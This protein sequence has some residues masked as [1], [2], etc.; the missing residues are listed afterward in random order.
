MLKNAG[1]Y[2]ATITIHN[3]V[4]YMKPFSFILFLMLMMHLPMYALDSLILNQKFD[5]LEIAPDTQRVRLLG[6]IAWLLRVR[7]NEK[8]KTMAEEGM[9]LS[10]ELG[11]SLSYYNLN[12]KLGVVFAIQSSYAESISNIR[13]S[14]AY[15]DRNNHK[16][17]EIKY[18]ALLGAVLDYYGDYPQADSLLQNVAQYY[19]ITKNQEKLL[20]VYLS[21]GL[22]YLHWKKY[23]AAKK[24][25]MQALEISEALDNKKISAKILNNLGIVEAD[26][27]NYPLAL[28]YY[29]KAIERKF[30]DDLFRSKLLNNIGIL[31]FNL[32]QWDK[33]IEY[34]QQSLV[35]KEKLGLKRYIANSLNNIGCVLESKLNYGEALTYYNRS[36]AI[37][38]KM[39]GTNNELGE[40]INNIGNVYLKLNRYK[41]AIDHFEQ[42]LAICIEKEN[43][44]GRARALNN[45]AKVYLEQNDILKALKYGTQSFKVAKQIN[46]RKTIENSSKIVSESYEASGD[47]KNALYFKNQY[48]TVKDSILGAEN[49]LKISKIEKRYETKERENELSAQRKRNA[50]LEQQ[51]EIDRLKIIALVLSCLMLSFV[52]IFSFYFL[53]KK[54]K[55]FKKEQKLLGLEIENINLQKKILNQK[56]V[57]QGHQLNDYLKQLAD[58]NELL[59][60]LKNEIS[61][62]TSNVQNNLSVS[63]TIIE[64]LNKNLQSETDWQ[65]FQHHFNKIHKDFFRN[66]VGDFP[67]LTTYD[68]NLSALIKLN[69]DNKEIAKILGISSSSVK[70]ARQRLY[71]KMELK[72]NETLRNYLIQL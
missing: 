66:L 34:H 55:N 29:L 25:F 23:A 18:G 63:S 46:A 40:T 8:A 16:E 52:I 12:A 32:E 26:Q 53:N 48:W 19:E 64:L 27:N 68:I 57:E 20:D 2:L 67:H 56:I 61:K 47:F 4:A 5:Q 10:L 3:S 70:K 31:Y 15:F 39:D 13:Q 9:S 33:A 49:S 17:L 35:I 69:L 14:L 59:L 62:A 65:K 60:H 71:A 7:D 43:E 58:K 11:D 36:L 44:Y 28:E 51:Q 6:E 38:K 37:K 30:D 21:I 54:R 45:L 41:E 42:Y 50:Y 22:N 24:T 72:D 1:Y